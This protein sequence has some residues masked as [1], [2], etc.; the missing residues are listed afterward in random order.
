MGATIDDINWIVHKSVGSSRLCKK[1]KITYAFFLTHRM[2][3]WKKLGATDSMD[4]LF[5][6]LPP[7]FNLSMI[8]E[9]K[10]NATIISMDL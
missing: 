1:D 6:F 8:N 10:N 9:E 3:A 5:F 2:I 7:M 4:H